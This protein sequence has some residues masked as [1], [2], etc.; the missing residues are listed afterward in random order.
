MF[1]WRRQA[2]PKKSGT[3]QA[4]KNQPTYFAAAVSLVF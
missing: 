3:V 4:T 1:A 2:P